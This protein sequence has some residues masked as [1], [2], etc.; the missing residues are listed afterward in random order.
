VARSIFHEAALEY[1]RAGI[2]VFPCIAGFKKPA[3]INGFHDATVDED[4]INRWWQED[5]SYNVAFSP[6]SQGWSI[7]D[8]DGQK[9][10]DH[11]L[12]L[13]ETYEIPAETWT[14][15]TPR[16]Y[17]LY[18]EGDMP[19]SQGRL[20]SGIDTRT[21]S[22]YALLPPSH[23]VDAP[24]QAEGY[25]VADCDAEVAP[26]PEWLPA[27]LR[28]GRAQPVTVA[29]LI[30]L[31]LPV[32]ISRGRDY[33]KSLLPIRE[34]EGSSTAAYVAAAWLKSFGVSQDRAV[35]LMLEFF[36]CTP[37]DRVWIEEVVPNGYRYS[38]D[39]PGSYAVTP[40]SEA[41]AGYVAKLPKPDRGRF[42]PRDVAEM[43]AQADPAWLIPGLIPD[44]DTVAWAGQTGSYKS[45]LSLD[46]ALCVATGE[47]TYIGV[48]PT[49][50]GH[51]F[52]GV[53]EGRTM[54]EKA[55][56]K[57]WQTL[58][59][60]DNTAMSRFHTLPAPR[61]V[62]EGEVQAFM[63]TIKAYMTENHPGE[64]VT[65]I[66]IDTVAKSMAGLKEDDA[67]DAGLYVQVCDNLV[68][69]FRCPNI[70][71]HHFGKD[72][73]R[74]MRGSSAFQAGFGTTI[75]IVR[76]PKTSVVSVRVVQHKDAE[77]PEFPWYLET[78]ALGKSIVFNSIT[79]AE[80]K[81]A[82]AE[83]DV[84][85]HKLVSA[86]LAKLNARGEEH[87]VTSYVLATEMLRHN[88]GGD[89][90]EA[91]QKKLSAAARK[92]TK[93]ARTKLGGYV[94]FVGREPLWFLPMA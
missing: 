53:L 88:S 47:T 1:A 59:G 69:Q 29:S 82:T 48:A 12:K 28:E 62:I 81:I 94:R 7:V 16:G 34:G 32:N 76:P 4:Q 9:G 40:P 5:P 15:R 64:P 85:G 20:A 78:K 92:L 91:W 30:P 27:K 10:K 86:A 42:W 17:H 46:V 43:E 75:E 56:R 79:A 65:L 44:L 18:Y 19:Q 8:L 57:A 70:S 23:T 52:Y 74:G 84:F 72:V 60:L 21:S 11:W 41:F 93:L 83:D 67:R 63:D 77:E 80:F 37:C 73:T 31:D 58:H 39:A 89:D 36:P 61:L 87:G 50:V 2:P 24:G 3:C 14:V 13:A 49:R 68:E 66:L 54:L 22:G 6:G 51:V 35:E 33:L 90:V 38:E 55:R 45:F 71:I 25:Y 26:L